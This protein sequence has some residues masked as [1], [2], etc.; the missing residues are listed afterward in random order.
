MKQRWFAQKVALVTGSSRGIGNAIARRFAAAGCDVVVNYRKGAGASQRGAEELC[1]EIR[2]MGRQAAAVQADISVKESVKGMFE[3]I[4]NRFGSLDFLVLNAARAPFRPLEKL[5]EREL[6]QLVETNF[7]GHLF[8]VQRALPML[9]K[10][11][12]KV[13]FLSSLGS[14]FYNPSYPLGSMKAAM[15]CVVRDLAE[16]LRDR[17]VAVNGVCA[18]LARTDSL[19]VLRQYW[20]GLERLPD[21]YFVEPDEIADV[22]LFLCGPE[23]RGILG[24]TLV[25][26]RGTS[27]RLYLPVATG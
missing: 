15:E 2:S 23:S 27:N 20:E 25:V 8:C 4:Q 22:V 3:E 16:S 1:E 21:R 14:R 12:G 17:R 9:E 19:K 18:G 26:D 13:V 11:Q 5:L 6:R 24:Q 7:F 10:T